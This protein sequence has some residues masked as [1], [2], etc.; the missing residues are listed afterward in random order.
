MFINYNDM[1]K[2]QHHDYCD[3][4]LTAINGGKT[5]G[6]LVKFSDFEVRR[7]LPGCTT[8]AR[9]VARTSGGVFNQICHTRSGRCGM[10][11]G[12]M[13]PISITDHRPRFQNVAQPRSLGTMDQ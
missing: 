5:P 1:T 8:R 7:E 12:L 6:D 10:P 13:A 4:Y 3:F 9:M 11:L 2:M